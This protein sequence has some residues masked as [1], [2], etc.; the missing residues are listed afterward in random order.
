MR[1]TWLLA[2]SIA[3]VGCR[4][5]LPEYT[6]DASADATDA[7]PDAPAPSACL[8]D[9]TYSSFDGHRYKVLPQ[10]VDYDTA[11]DACAA[12]GAHLAVIDSAAENDYARSLHVAFAVWIGLDDLSVEGTF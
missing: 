7:P 8:L 2:A 9:S 11:I 10:A 1:R 12:D 4:L 3:W 5:N 6:I